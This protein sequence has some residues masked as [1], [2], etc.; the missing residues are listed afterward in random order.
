VGLPGNWRLTI[1]GRGPQKEPLRRLISDL[2]LADRV[3]LLDGVTDEKKAQLLSECD[4]FVHPAQSIAEAFG[5]SIAEAFASGKPVVL[6]DL[7]TGVSF[8]SRGGE[9]GGSARVGSSDSIRRVIHKLLTSGDLRE[10]CGKSNA[11][12]WQ[13]ELTLARF[14]DR[15]HGYLKELFPQASARLAASKPI[16]FQAKSA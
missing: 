14:E 10:K 15:Y 5:I 6:T 11:A 9:C 7:P 2:G 3:T 13:K 12:F 4:I 8:L 16:D 1:V